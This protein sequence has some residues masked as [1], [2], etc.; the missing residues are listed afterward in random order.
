MVARVVSARCIAPGR[1]LPSLVM[2]FVLALTAAQPARAE[3][4]RLGLPLA[5]EPQKTCFVQHYVDVAPEAGTQDYRC[6]HSTYKGHTGVDFRILSAAAA[7]QGVAVLAA[8][9]G[10]VTRKRDGMVDS[11]PR[12]TASGKDGLKGV[13]C[14]NAVVID[15][16][17]GWE[18]QYCHLRQGSVKVEIGQK[19]ER[20]A[21]LGDVGFSGLA[22]T[23]HLHLTVRH[24]GRTIDPFT[25]RSPDGTCWR[26]GATTASLFDEAVT[27]AFPYRDGAI[28]Q[29]G[30]ASRPVS[31][32]ELEHD[33]NAAQPVGTD[34]DAVVFF[35]RITHLRGGDKVQLTVTG[36]GGFFVE[37]PGAVVDR[38]KAIFIAHAGKKRTAPRWAE[39]TYTGEVRIVRDGAVVAR[40]SRFVTLP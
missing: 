36:P 19:V 34:S 2:V 27:S 30:F 10:T 40:D 37:S 8:A 4:P 29:L 25:G 35:A 7:R 16:G 38:D 13:E 11:F 23:A 6:G 15:H 33:H 17:D 21:P 12:E 20:G 9:P 5:C 24:Q 28:L 3:A 26:E 14:G 39:G 1:P 18:T 32:A 31:W 22:D